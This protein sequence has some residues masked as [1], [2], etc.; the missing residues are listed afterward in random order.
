MPKH[1]TKDLLLS[2]GAEIIHRRGFQD[3]G[4]LEI[5]E[6][7][8]VPK[9]SFYYYFK[10]K[11]DFGLQVIDVYAAV[12]FQ[13][14]QD[15]ISL[16]EV[17]AVEKIRQFFRDM[18]DRASQGGFSGCPLGNVSQEMGE[19]NKTLRDKLEE[20]FNRLEREIA[21]LL[22]EAQVDSEID[23]KVNPEQMAVFLVNSWEGALIRMK[24]TRDMVPF[25]IFERIAF[26]EK[27]VPIQPKC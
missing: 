4:I 21:A 18:T 7:A 19:I 1:N 10:S 24:L 23:S 8:G 5:L 2:K 14:L 11:E 26:D 9:G 13:S 15:N 22:R 12:M 16:G 20:I 25:E 27:L 6:A 17:S 3:T